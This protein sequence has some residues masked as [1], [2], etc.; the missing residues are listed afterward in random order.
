MAMTEFQA[1]AQVPG[2]AR[3]A[4]VLEWLREHANAPR[5]THAGSDHLSE[6][7]LG[8]V[9]GLGGG[10]RGG[11]G[12]WREG[13]VPPWLEEFAAMCFREVPFC[14]AQGS[15]PVDFFDIPPCGREDV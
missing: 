14:R 3:G 12:V 1:T 9:L 15:R 5:Y 2:E 8:G 13:E 4:Q 10:V 11:G 6:A 7:G